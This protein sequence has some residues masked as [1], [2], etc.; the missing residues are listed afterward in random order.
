MTIHR[1]YHQTSHFRNWEYF[2]RRVVHVSAWSMQVSQNPTVLALAEQ[3]KLPGAG[4]S[5]H[6]EKCHAI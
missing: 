6:R 1:L 5:E 2:D 4:T 3:R